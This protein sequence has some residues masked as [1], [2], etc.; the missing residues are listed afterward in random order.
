MDILKKA[1][2]R[3]I[4]PKEDGYVMNDIYFGEEGL[5][6]TSANHVSAMANVMVNDLKQH[7]NGL[8]LYR[9]YIRVIGE[10]ET[11]VE[12][13]NDTLPEVIQTVERISKANALI[14]W[15]REAIKERE[16]ALNDVNNTDINTYAKRTG[17]EMIDRPTMPQEPRVNFQD[18]KTMLD[19][20]LTVKEYNRAMELNSTLAVLGEFV[21]EKGLLT[22][23]KA[24]L[25]RIAKN[26]V[27]V[28]ESGRDTIITRYEADDAAVIDEVYT[29][30]QARYR[31]LQAEKNG[32]DNKW[33]NMAA[34][35]QVRR[36]AEYQTELNAWKSECAKW[37]VQYAMLKDHW[38]TWKKQE[39]DRIAALKII[40]PKDLVNLY[41]ELRDKYM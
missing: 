4:L 36:R 10:T 6:S 11:L 27:E 29:E 1:A 18:Y 23:H 32:I 24:E 17:Y 38:M 30:L 9:K 35:Y 34:E 5:T 22:K 41:T 31:K 28:K 39:C 33:S 15:L 20:G 25:Q 8:R 19:A 3:A 2:E 16:N 37:D 13:R 40:I 21:H 7:I 26:P 12:E 14:A